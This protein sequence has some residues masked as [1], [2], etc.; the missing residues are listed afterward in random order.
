MTHKSCQ[1]L[2]E[3]ISPSQLHQKIA[4]A[5]HQLGWEKA[6]REISED[7]PKIGEKYTTQ[8][9][10]EIQFQYFCLALQF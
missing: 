5:M 1:V 4:H 7:H 2:K 9:T 10:N 6:I 8:Q 3:S